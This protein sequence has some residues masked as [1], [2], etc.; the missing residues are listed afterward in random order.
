[1]WESRMLTGDIGYV[2]L[3]DF[4]MHCADEVQNAIQTLSGQGM[5]KLIFD[6]RFN[7]GGYV[8][9]AVQIA[10]L[11]LDEGVV[12]YTVYADGSEEEYLSYDDKY[13]I[14]LVVLV[15]EYSASSAEILTGALKDRGCCDG[16][17]H[18]DVRQGHHPVDVS[19]VRRWRTE[20]DHSELFYAKRYK[21]PWHRH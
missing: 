14:P 18:Q 1:M 11:F 8:N 4:S 6:L 2:S 9:S 21:N 15:N 3:S 16:G 19:A 10:D 13:D 17:G 7:P 12:V 20:R 5:K